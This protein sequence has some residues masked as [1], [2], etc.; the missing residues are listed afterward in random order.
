[1]PDADRQTAG[2]PILLAV[3]GSA[4]AGLA[5]RAAEVEALARAR[6]PGR[7]VVACVTGDA[8]TGLV[9]HGEAGAGSPGTDRGGRVDTVAGGIPGPASPLGALLREA[10]RRAAPALA[11]VAG[12]PREDGIDWLGALLAPIVEERFDFV[13]PAYRRHP[14]EGA[15]TTAIVHPL[16]RMAFGRD[17]RQPLGGEAAL[18]PAFARRLLADPDWRRDPVH[19]GSDAWLVAK[20][21][22]G[23]ER[24]CQ[25]WLGPRP[26]ATADPEEPSETLVRALGL[27]FRELE[28]HA[29][30]WQR[31]GPP[32]PVPTFG[33]GGFLPG[34][35]PRLPAERYARALQLGQR[36]LGEVWGLVL[37]PSTR[38]AIARAAAADP[39][40]L[41]DPLWARIVCDFA[42]AHMA[43][44][45]EPGQLLRSLTPLYLGWLAG[46]ARE[47]DRSGVAGAEARIGAICAAYDGER[48]HL[49]A[50]WR[51]PDGFT[52]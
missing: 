2:G 9:P 50:R 35:G 45:V 42:V 15:L 38:L 39:V 47:L 19:A 11:L 49:V 34:D 25:A 32:R 18:S 7:E 8:G 26:R 29:P 28:R 10:D 13:C 16:M 31:A 43:R 51:W 41:D 27:V 33:D 5:A 4:S 20:A 14:A 44:V 40:A 12:Q 3:V 21:L 24:L 6:F 1:M 37:S 30:R 48:H 23:E 17:L 46:F 36:E 52:P 22:T